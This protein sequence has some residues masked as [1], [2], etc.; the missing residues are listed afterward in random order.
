MTRADDDEAPLISCREDGDDD[1]LEDEPRLDTAGA[2]D[3]VAKHRGDEQRIGSFV[4]LLTLS[5]C[6]SGLLFGC[7]CFPSTHPS[8]PP[9][10]CMNSCLLR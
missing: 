8:F 2:G 10:L 9:L 3:A 6:I 1:G 7:K 4:W 5:A